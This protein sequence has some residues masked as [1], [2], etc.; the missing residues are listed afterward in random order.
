M[1]QN[2]ESSSEAI[3]RPTHLQP[4]PPNTFQDNVYSKELQFIHAN[5]K[6]ET[7]MLLF[8]TF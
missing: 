3:N 1:K 2:I 4:I 5:D 6:V 7:T 8:A